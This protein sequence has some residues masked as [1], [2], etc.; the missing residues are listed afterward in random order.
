[1]NEPQNG[2]KPAIHDGVTSIKDNVSMLVD[3]GS[4]TVDAIKSRVADVTQQVKDQS[5]TAVDRTTSFVEA[6][7]FKS[8][9][10]AFGIGY[11]A[12]RI[13][14]SPLVKLAMIGGLGML[15]SRIVRR[16]A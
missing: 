16:R 14:T 10:L 15:G 5:A 7:P 3:Q 9:L 13:R 2:I 11:V 8:L 12:M 4:A 6:N 1:M